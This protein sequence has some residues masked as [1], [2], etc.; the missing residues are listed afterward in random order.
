MNF[1]LEKNR[2]IFSQLSLDTQND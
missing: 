2:F 1:S